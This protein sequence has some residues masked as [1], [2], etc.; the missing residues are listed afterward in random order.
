MTKY[1]K[2]HY[3]GEQRNRRAAAR[4]LQVAQLRANARIQDSQRT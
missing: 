4:S 2:F 3:G 1:N